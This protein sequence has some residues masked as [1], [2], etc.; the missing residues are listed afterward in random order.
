[1]ELYWFFCSKESI[2]KTNCWNSAPAPSAS[3]GSTG[4]ATHLSQYVLCSF[5]VVSRNRFPIYPHFS[6][7]MSPSQGWA[8]VF[9]NALFDCFCVVSSI[10][11]PSAVFNSSFVIVWVAQ[12]KMFWAC[13]A[14]VPIKLSQRSKLSR[15]FAKVLKCSLLAGWVETNHMFLFLS[16]LCYEAEQQM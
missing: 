9:L 15:I 1:M 6:S 12:T 10:V 8:A 2:H 16:A 4:Y 5:A 14:N 7:M 13:F 3:S 11:F